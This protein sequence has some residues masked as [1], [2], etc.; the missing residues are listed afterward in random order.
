MK[1]EKRITVNILLHFA[2]N[3]LGSAALTTQNVKPKI[4]PNVESMHYVLKVK[5]ENILVPLNEPEKL[6]LSPQF[7]RSL[8]LIFM[9]TGW[10]TNFN[11]S[12]N[13]VLDKIY[14]AYRCRGNYNF[15]VINKD[16]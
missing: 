6:W 13:P 16:F 8:P 7:N 1:L 3:N 15:V 5:D 4:L 11:K 2:W 12:T 10:T 9:I 14:A